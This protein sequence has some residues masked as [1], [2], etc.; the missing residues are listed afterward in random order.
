MNNPIVSTTSPSTATPIAP[1]SRASSL[2]P[3]HIHSPPVALSLSLTTKTQQRKIQQKT[4]Q[5]ADVSPT[6]SSLPTFTPAASIPSPPPISST[7]SIQ[8]QQQQQNIEKETVQNVQ[9][10]ELPPPAPPSFSNSRRKLPSV[11]S[12]LSINSARSSSTRSIR[13][14]L[15]LPASPKSPNSGQHLRI[16]QSTIPPAFTGASNLTM[17]PLIRGALSNL[18]LPSRLAL[19]GNSTFSMFAAFSP[20]YI[21]NSVLGF[22]YVWKG[23]KEGKFS[24]ELTCLPWIFSKSAAR[25]WLFMRLLFIL[26]F[27]L[28]F[29][30]IFAIKRVNVGRTWIWGAVLSWAVM[31]QLSRFRRAPDGVMAFCRSLGAPEIE[32]YMFSY[33]LVE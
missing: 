3:L 22:M 32:E 15:H 29:L 9:T 1:F 28:L 24:R 27:I 25:M 31:F 18:T 30:D 7:T 8:Q 10:S 11:P 5:L 4:N 16:P 33:R 6:T 17:P 23:W 20:L 13:N 26:L 2:P 19:L 12:N 21:G 14:N